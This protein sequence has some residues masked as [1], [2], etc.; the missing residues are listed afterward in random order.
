MGLCCHAVMVSEGTGVPFKSLTLRTVAV[1][2]T[3]G[4]E[5]ILGPVTPPVCSIQLNSHPKPEI[6]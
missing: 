1:N 6:A 2:S 3:H 5:G 4:L